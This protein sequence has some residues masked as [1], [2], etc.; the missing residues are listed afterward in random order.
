MLVE[1]KRIPEKVQRRA[2]IASLHSVRPNPT[3]V[4][5][6]FARVRC[7]LLRTA[8]SRKEHLR[9]LRQMDTL[10]SALFEYAGVCLQKEAL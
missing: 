8:I 4:S 9:T 2:G 10:K 7:S 1:L 6:D 3:K 5:A